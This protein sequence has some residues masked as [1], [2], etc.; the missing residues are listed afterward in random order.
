MALEPVT[1]HV[2]GAHNV[3]NALGALATALELG[4]DYDALR[5]ALA[6]FRGAKRRFQH[7]GDAGGVTI[8]DDYAHHPTELAATL[9]AA[10]GRQRAGGAGRI[11]GLF[12]PH[13]YSRTQAL[14]EDFGRALLDTDLLVVTG[15]YSAG[16][17]PI[18]GVSGLTI[19]QSALDAGHP[20]AHYHET[21]E[22]TRKFLAATLRP[23]DML[24]TMGAGNVYRVG[25]Q[26]LEDLAVQTPVG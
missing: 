20:D 13:R 14:A 10:R 7:K 9:A 1:L 6:A 25:E 19:A 5:R 17:A 24:L 18:E 2:A 3:S 8:I 16:E 22:D 12:Q 26:L 15:V 21:L 11:V 23:G 4:A